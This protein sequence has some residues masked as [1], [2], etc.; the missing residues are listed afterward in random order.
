MKIVHVASEMFPYVKTGGL[1]DVVGALAQALAQK[2]HEVTVFLPGYRAVLDHPEVAP[3]LQRTR[4][5]RIQM[6]DMFMTGDVREFTPEPNLKI[7]LICREEFFDRRAPYG[8]GER[9]YEDN[10]HRFIFFC[11]GV[12]EVMRLYE[13]D[14]DVVHGHDWQ[15]G[16]LPLLLRS[17]E[18]RHG[19]NLAM[20]TVHTIHNI[21]FQGLFPMRSFYRTN[22]PKEFMGIDGVEYYGQA[23][24]MKAGLLFAD[25]V[26]TV[27]P[28]YAKEIQTSEYGC[29][30][31][32]VVQTRAEDL[33]G[34]V[35]GIDSAIW[36]PAT[37]ARLPAT[38]SASDLAGKT[39]CRKAL[40]ASQGF[41]PEFS[42]TVFGMVCRLTEQKG[43][44]FVLANQ[45]FFVREEVRLIVLGAGD[46]ALEEQMQLLAAEHPGK[47]AYKGALDEN[48]SHLVEAGSD[49]FLMPS[50]FEPCGLNQMYSQVYGTVPV[51]T[52][53][54]GLLDTVTD[55]DSDP[56]AGTGIL[57]EATDEGVGKGLQ[58]A[59]ALHGDRSAYAAV[60]QRGMARDFGWATATAAYEAFYAELMG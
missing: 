25:R 40:L 5:L 29:G 57:V 26:T 15:A 54:G 12:V 51:V 49:F 30:L 14:A 37:D 36:N 35:N 60:Q 27:S 39:A 2:G 19:L 41:D 4:R 7:C 46:A 22:L 59:L 18:Q 16:L 56:A 10:H 21:A 6:G 44:Q 55:I 13:I 1:A 43:V 3:L 48:L 8:N 11:K 34:M 17:A 47:V 28:Q 52:R 53:V 42:G 50:L 38:Y 20:H 23:S 45:A 24:M 33:V 9:D 32:G 31:D 58:R